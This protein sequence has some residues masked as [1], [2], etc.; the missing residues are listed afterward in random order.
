LRNQDIPWQ[1]QIHTISFHKPSPS[2]ANKGKTATQEGKLHSR[3][4]KKRPILLKLF[5]KTEAKDTLPNLFYEATITLTPKPH[6]DPSKKEL[7][8][9]FPYEY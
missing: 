7:Q 1:K 8:T 2:K 9:N 3:K 4:S 6:K 5:H